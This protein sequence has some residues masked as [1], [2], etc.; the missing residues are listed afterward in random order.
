MVGAGGWP[1][2]TGVELR[3]LATFEHAVIANDAHVPLTQRFGPGGLA[4]NPHPGDIR[5]TPRGEHGELAGR[6]DAG[7]HLAID[8]AIGGESEIV[9]K[10]IRVHVTAIRVGH[11]IR[12]GDDLGGA[13]FGFV[14]ALL[15]ECCSGGRRA[16]RHDLAD[17]QA[18][19]EENLAPPSLLRG[20]M[21]GLRAPADDG[22]LVAPGREREQ[23]TTRTPALEAVDIDEAV[24][25]LELRLELLGE[26]EIV[27]PAL[28][29]RLNLE[30]HRKHG[31]CSVLVKL[32]QAAAGSGHAPAPC[33]SRW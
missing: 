28:L 22:L 18:V 5:V 19:V 27:A 31:T 8:Q 17:A 29:S 14:E 4:R 21:I 2:H 30:D 9:S 3:R 32:T 33:A 11:D 12:D 13:D 7:E 26:I 23:A 15:I 16:V 24:D 20:V 6:V 25:R 1:L 10:T